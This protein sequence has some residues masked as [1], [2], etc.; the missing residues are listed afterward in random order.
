MNK[1]SIVL[2]VNDLNFS[3]PLTECLDKEGLAVWNENNWDSVYS[4]ILDITPCLV[5]LDLAL[6]GINGF[7]ACKQIRSIFDGYLLLLS[8]EDSELEQIIALEMGADD[9]LFKPTPIRLLFA[10]IRALLRRIDR[11][12]KNKI[13]KSIS[14]GDLTV[15]AARRE[16]YLN[17][18]LL[19]LTTIQFDLL[20]FLISNAGNILSRDDICREVRNTNYN[21]IDRSIDVYISRLR[22]KLGDDPSNP[23]Y[24]K[25]VRGTGYLFADEKC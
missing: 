14:V 17:D 23:F 9:F 8:A 7:D 6:P 11:I 12:K 3:V 25:T 13:T 21:G 1:N 18:K 22:Q 15:N 2:G 4:R 19:D 20:W 5:V 24:L 10:R 16:A